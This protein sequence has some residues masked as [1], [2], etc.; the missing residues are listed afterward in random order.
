MNRSSN[1]QIS[2]KLILG[3]DF[4]TTFSA[5]SYALHE[6]NN[7]QEPSTIALNETPIQSVQFDIGKSQVKTQIAW[8][9]AS[10][11]Y[12]WGDD[13][14]EHV[15]DGEISERDRIV[16]LK[17]GLD[18]SDATKDIRTKQ[19]YQLARIP[20]SR[21]DDRSNPRQPLIEDLI[22]VYLKR[23]YMFAKEKIIKYYGVRFDGNIFDMADVQCAICVPAIWTPETNQ[24]MVTAAEN[25]A[26]P[27]P[28]IVSEAEGAAAFVMYEQQ[29]QATASAQRDLGRLGSILLHVG[30]GFMVFRRDC[31]ADLKA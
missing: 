31:I 8:H 2:R 3:I 6:W 11:E 5:V 12:I 21:W 4:G 17:L 23:L 19:A 29:K 1:P 14:D 22:G 24:V 9:A 20:P 13:V 18:K 15:T 25:A 26:L 28:D 30:D 7:S 16:M 27:N 10:Q